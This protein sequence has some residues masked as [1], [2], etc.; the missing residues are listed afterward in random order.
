MFYSDYLKVED[1]PA[2]INPDS[3]KAMKADWWIKT[4][5]HPTFIDLLDK[6]EKM[7]SRKGFDAK[8]SLWVHGAYGTGKSRVIMTLKKLLECSPDEFNA[9]FDKYPVEFHDTPDLQAKLLAQRDS[10]KI[11]TVYHYSASEINDFSDFIMTIYEDVSKALKMAKVPYAGENTLRGGIVAWLEKDANK[12]YFN[13]LIGQSE[14][15]GIGS[16]AGN[17]AD[18]I[19]AKLKTPNAKVKELVRDILS[20]ADKEGIKAFSKK[21][22]DVKQWLTDVIDQNHLKAIVFFWDEFSSFFQK[23]KNYLDV[24]QTFNELSNDKP[25]YMII[26]TH[27]QEGRKVSDRFNEVEIEMPDTIAFN[28]INHVIQ[29]KDG[30]SENWKKIVDTLQTAMLDA[31]KAVAKCVWKDKANEGIAKLNGILPIHPLAALLL[32]HISER[33]ASNQR[34]MFNFIKNEDSTGLE[35]FQWFI[36]T[37][38]PEPNG[39]D[40][41][42]FLTIDNLWNFFYEK[43]T[44]KHTDVAGKSNLDIQVRNILDS[45]IAAENNPI[46][47]KDQK[48]VLK[49][50]LM[51]Q[52]MSLKT[53]RA[54]PLLIPTEE[55]LEL[56]YKGLM[57]QP[58]TASGIARQLVQDRV[59]FTMI[60]RNGKTEFAATTVSNDRAKIDE[61]KEQLKGSIDTDQLINNGELE[62]AISLSKSHQFRFKTFALS[63]KTFTAD[64]KKISQNEVVDKTIK[65][66]QIPLV[67]LFARTAEERDKLRSGVK[68]MIANE[69]YKNIVFVDL[70]AANLA[71]DELDKYLEY[72]AQEKFYREAG[73]TS[74]ANNH[75]N[76][77][78]GILQTWKNNIV[79][80]VKTVYGYHKPDG[81]NCQ[82]NRD[83]ESALN[84]IVLHQYPKSIDNYKF[85]EAAWNTNQAN[86]FL[87]LGVVERS[88]NQIPQTVPQ[89]IQDNKATMDALKTELD[90]YIQEQLHTADGRVAFSDVWNVL[91]KKGFMPCNVYAYLTGWLLRDYLDGTYR[92]SDGEP[93]NDERLDIVRLGV[94]VTDYF[95]QIN[96]S[97]HNYKDKYIEIL[98]TEQRAFVDLVHSVWGDI[99]DDLSV[100]TVTT[101]IRR[102]LMN[103]DY[104]L[105]AIAEELNCHGAKEFLGILGEL[106]NVRNVD[107][108]VKTESNKVTKLGKLAIANSELGS[109]LKSLLTP[110]KAKEAMEKFLTHF[111]SGAL[112]SLAEEI[113]AP[114]V[115]YEVKKAFSGNSGL[116]LWDQETGEDVIRRLINKYKFVALSNKALLNNAV[117]YDAALNNWNEKIKTIRIPYIQ[118]THSRPEVKDLLKF[119]DDRHNN[120]LPD[121]RIPALVSELEKSLDAFKSFDDQMLTVFKDAFSYYLNDLSDSDVQKLYNQLPSD[122]FYKPVS[123]TQAC[124]TQIANSIK[125]GQL[126]TKLRTLWKEKTGTE[127]PYEWSEKY[128]TPILAMVPREEQDRA[129]A[130]FDAVNNSRAPIQSA[131]Q[132]AIN[133][134]NGNHDYFN[135]LNNQEKIDQ[136]FMNRIVHRYGSL[137]NDPNKVRDKLHQRFG[138][139]YSWLDSRDVN[140]YVS[141][142]GEEQYNLQG[143]SKVQE[144]V[145]QMNDEQVKKLLM[146]LVDN[147]PETGIKILTEYEG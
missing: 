32:K 18:D 96:D 10:G 22:D 57:W 80:E 70:T 139:C 98:S 75:K 20:M 27:D 114:N 15:R 135:N 47:T 141:H 30:Q 62:S 82:T 34:S 16:F 128:R 44:D 144:K 65:P 14:Y 146:W 127:T 89:Y 74:Q 55:N 94:I 132:D 60:D 95:K 63:Y 41:D 88:G 117:S 130:V 56:A 90:G 51:M 86:N 73:D 102:K 39:N 78:E 46:F 48:R 58:G 25:F 131:V 76:L 112:L 83:L 33:F 35:A 72:L 116:W 107:G 71:D 45:F 29:V 37:H 137:L 54:I 67:L 125:E 43:G 115:L 2:E 126:Y 21:T 118:I 42:S 111:E 13:E 59:L 3:I 53:N 99:S 138:N 103:L 124:I 23:N 106:A 113:H 109:I 1:F 143:L 100:E 11:V 19:L 84:D 4:Y 104:P 121:D 7:L 77:A 38:S 66:F 61:Y 17:T 79:N 26:V 129:R 101:E 105:W 134:L 93:G 85:T 6:T 69:G 108:S 122:T 120:E 5:P 145:G 12:R 142:M 140:D 68:T 87:K 147:S 40:D 9:Y 52:A 24:F 31:A 81:V 8:K 64:V 119:F 50:V 133:Y 110:A 136:A 91:E 123:Q 97:K 92:T 36:Q 49:T 28:L